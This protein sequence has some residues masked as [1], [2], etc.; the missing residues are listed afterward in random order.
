MRVR[1]PSDKIKYGQFSI[2]GAGEPAASESCAQSLGR[3]RYM[4]VFQRVD[5]LD[6][7]VDS[8]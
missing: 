8:R 5:K 2:N 7:I 4:S 1:T 3:N 6:N